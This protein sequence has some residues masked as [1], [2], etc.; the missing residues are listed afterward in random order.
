ML[1]DLITSAKETLLDR[2]T[3]PLIGSFVLAWPLWNYKF[4]VILLSSNSVTVTFH[5]IETVAFR[6]GWEVAWRGVLA[7]LASALAYVFLYPY[8]A[9]WVF[10]FVRTHQ[11]KLNRIKQD[12][13]G[14]ELLSVD[15]SRALRKA[16]R[17]ELDAVE[18]RNDGLENENRRM[19]SAVEQLEKELREVRAAAPTSVEEIS[20]TMADDE[21]RALYELAKLI[22]QPDS[23]GRARFDQIA[24]HLDLTR[25]MTEYLL[26][27][28][29]ARS[30]VFEDGSDYELTAKGRKALMTAQAKRN[31]TVVGGTARIGS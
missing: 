31:P 13:E 22:D 7:P 30:F 23:G 6:S 18:R 21:L 4:L 19:R 1:N 9:T 3:S 5:L 16:V 24:A 10:R 26:D 29:K 14:S 28:L 20:V 25:T 27:G 12:I 17:A 11:A 8:P 2:L 15:E